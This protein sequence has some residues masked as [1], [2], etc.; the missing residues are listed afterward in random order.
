[1]DSKKDA[2]E[3]NDFTTAFSVENMNKD[4]NICKKLAE[5]H[6]V[7]MP[8]EMNV[9]RVYEKAM[10]KGYGKE[11]FSATIKIVREEKL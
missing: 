9:V 8:G 3:K 7:P 6:G 2:I 11:D 1:M 5:E 4:V 10:A